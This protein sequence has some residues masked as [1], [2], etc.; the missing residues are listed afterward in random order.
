MDNSFVEG[1]DDPIM[2]R[3]LYG[4]LCIQTKL[5]ISF[6]VQ[7]NVHWSHYELMIRQ[8]LILVKLYVCLCMWD[9]LS[10]HLFLISLQDT[11]RSTICIQ[12]K[13]RMEMGNVSKRQQPDQRAENSRMPPMSLQHIVEMI[14]DRYFTA[15]LSLK[16]DFG[17]SFTQF[18]SLWKRRF[19]RDCI[20]FYPF[21]QSVQFNWL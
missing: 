9:Y 6:A 3:Y 14:D 12:I 17:R 13:L 11:R 7:C 16:T 19:T 8:N 21:W 2:Y 15:S 1:A 4:I 20:C 18:C 10:A 5:V